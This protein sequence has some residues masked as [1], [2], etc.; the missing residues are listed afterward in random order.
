MS[1]LFRLFLHI[2]VLLL[3]TTFIVWFAATTADRAR[4]RGTAQAELING[5]HCHDWQDCQ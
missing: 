4:A 3:I 5:W 1:P 2:V